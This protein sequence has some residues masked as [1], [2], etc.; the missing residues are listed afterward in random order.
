MECAGSS[1]TVRLRGA[2]GLGDD[3]PAEDAVEEAPGLAHRAE[4]VRGDGLARERDEQSVERRVDRAREC[5]IL[6]GR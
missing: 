1:S 6:L 5:G 4:A 3:L 2:Q